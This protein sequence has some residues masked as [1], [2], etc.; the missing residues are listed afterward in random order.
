MTTSP[1]IIKGRST[2][3]WTI[4]IVAISLTVIACAVA[5]IL[6]LFSTTDLPFQ[7]FAALIGVII[8]AIITGVLLKGQSDA[9]RRLKE[10]SE[11]FKEKLA[12]YNRFLDSLRN[13]VT[14]STEANKKDVIFHAMAIRMHTKPDT[15]NA[16]DKN[17]IKLIEN[18]G[19]DTEVPA[20]VESLN[21]IALIFGKELYGE[22][23]LPTTDLHSFISAISGSQ[24]EPSEE[25]KLIE[26]TEEEKEDSDNLPELSLSDWD[27]KVRELRTKGWE[28]KEGNDSLQ[29]ISSSSPVEI[30]IYR[31]KGKYRVEVSKD[32]DNGFSQFLKDSFKGARRYGTWWRELPISN[33]GVTEG[34]LLTQLPTNDRARASVIKWIDKIINIL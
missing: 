34:T 11:I 19:T 31:K 29:I 24:E 30:S 7:T 9:E 2:G 28:V 1:D 18:T 13:Y 10:Q 6:R 27:E 23:M 33:Y 32:G 21:E 22:S 17:I 12:T 5:V 25:E 20:L 14:E 15:V 16:L 4:Y 8:T 26:A 3:S